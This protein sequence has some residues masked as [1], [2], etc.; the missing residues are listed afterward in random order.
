[1]SS[2]EVA[3][4]KDPTARIINLLDSVNEVSENVSAFLDSLS[5]TDFVQDTETN[6]WIAKS[7]Q[8]D[9]RWDAVDKAHSNLLNAR[10]SLLRAFNLSITS[11]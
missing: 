6:D 1:M 2:P 7:H 10:L 11:R 4:V 5:V 9:L 3:I 8:V